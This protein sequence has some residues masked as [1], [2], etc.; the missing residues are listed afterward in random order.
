MIFRQRLPLAVLSGVLL[1]TLNSGALFAAQQGP[2]LDRQMGPITTPSRYQP[3]VSA[4]RAAKPSQEYVLNQIAAGD[5]ADLDTFDGPGGRV[6]PADFITDLLTNVS[7][8]YKVDRHGISIRHATVPDSIDL[9]NG[10]IPYNVQLI[11]CTFEQKVDLTEATFHRNLVVDGSHFN[12]SVDFSDVT[13]A[14]QF[15]ASEAVFGT[16]GRSID[17]DGPSEIF[18]RMKVGSTVYLPDAQFEE[19]TDFTHSEVG[20]DFLA[21]RTTFNSRADLEGLKITFDAFFRHATFNGQAC[22]NDAHFSNLYLS[23]AAFNDPD[24]SEPTLF[25]G[26]KVDSAALDDVYVAGKIQL[27]DMNYQSLTPSSWERLKPL[28][29]SWHCGSGFYENLEASFRKRGFTEQADEIYIERREHERES[30]TG[31]T[32]VFKWVGDWLFDFF[33]GYGRRLGHLLIFALGLLIAGCFVFH[34]SGM[35]LKETIPS[36]DP[37]KYNRFWYSID[38]LIPIIALGQ[39]A[40]WRPEDYRPFARHYGHVHKIFGNILVPIGLAALTGVIK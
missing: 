37:P 13:I 35:K 32:R 5:I 10:E 11:D 1:S 8:D 9:T 34:G 30:F 25:G 36:R 40:A 23:D 38:L 18:L 12:G 7:P 4:P 31:R 17:S 27:E 28:V 2:T 19:P 15:S 6:L 16:P 24:E 33:L 3:N 26:L 20:G 29:S 14:N 21:D 22:L 39:E